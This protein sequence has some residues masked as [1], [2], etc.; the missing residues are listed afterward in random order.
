MPTSRRNEVKYTRSIFSI[1][2]DTMH[3]ACTRSLSSSSAL[4]CPIRG[5]GDCQRG[6]GRSGVYADAL[7]QARGER[8]GLRRTSRFNLQIPVQARP[9]EAQG[10]A[11]ESQAP[12]LE[13]DKITAYSSAA[14]AAAISLLPT[15][16]ASCDSSVDRTPALRHS[17]RRSRSPA[18][19]RAVL[20]RRDSFAPR[21]GRAA[22]PPARQTT[23]G[24][25][26]CA[27]P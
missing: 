11:R 9:S 22:G 18:H 14:A 15:P 3:N 1:L 26:K 19:D 13:L 16:A 20:D 2:Y 4:Q 5:L 25:D 17:F 10:V 27:C 12:S 23:P 6:G 7:A 8:A 21:F 24:I